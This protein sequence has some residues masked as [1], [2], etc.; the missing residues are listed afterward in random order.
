MINRIKLHDWYD[1]YCI[2]KIYS[3]MLHQHLHEQSLI[4]NNIVNRPVSSPGRHHHYSHAV[5]SHH[6]IYILC[7]RVI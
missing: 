2:A 3:R 6:S 7:I 5:P 1:V 4:I